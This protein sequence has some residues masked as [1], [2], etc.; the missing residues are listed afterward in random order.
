MMRTT[1]GG[2]VHFHG[3]GQGL[4]EVLGQ[5]AT[6]TGNEV[7]AF[8]GLGTELGA[9]TLTVRGHAKD[10]A[11]QQK[12]LGFLGQNDHFPG[13]TGDAD[14]I[15]G[16]SGDH[17]KGART[18]KNDKQGSDFSYSDQPKLVRSRGGITQDKTTCSAALGSL[19]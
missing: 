5:G 17:R 18:G 4:P 9:K 3:A 16:I 13:R 19:I 8:D 7:K 12:T 14:R 11:L 6:G 10:E 2:L 1:E 15:H